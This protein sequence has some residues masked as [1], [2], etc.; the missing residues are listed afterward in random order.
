MAEYPITGLCVVADKNR[1]PD[2]YTVIETTTDNQDADLWK[3]KLLRKKTT[4]Y[5]CYTKNLTPS[6][7]DNVVVDVMVIKE[8]ESIPAGYSCIGTTHDSDE[9]VLK[10]RL[11]VIQLFNRKATEKA[12]TEIY[13]TS[14]K[15]KNKPV[16]VS[17]RGDING[18]N[19][20]LRLG[21]VMQLIPKEAVRKAP[22]PAPRQNLPLPPQ[23]STESYD[24]T[25]GLPQQS[26]PSQLPYSWDKA[27]TSRQSTLRTSHSHSL[28]TDVLS[29]IEGV[30]FQINSALQATTISAYD[31]PRIP[32]KSEL[33][34]NNQFYYDFNFEAQTKQRLTMCDSP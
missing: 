5:M 22:V 34:I 33:E 20:F 23:S 21:P 17:P 27:R 14:S 19:L 24:N 8:N 25:Y 6:V 28:E 11:L 10:K 31:V 4:R 32:Y 3:D 15:T 30:P 7:G 1:C 29:A 2:G 9:P 16:E 18:I 12:I 13:L 26:G